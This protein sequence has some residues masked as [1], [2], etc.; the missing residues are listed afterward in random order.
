MFRTR[1]SKK[2]LLLDCRFL[3]LLFGLFLGFL[4]FL[5]FFFRRLLLGFLFGYRS[6]RNPAYQVERPCPYGRQLVKYDVLYRALEVVLLPAHR[7][8]DKVLLG[9]LK[10][11]ANKPGCLLAGYPVPAY[12][13]YPPVPLHEVSQKHDVTDV[14]S[15]AL[16]LHGVL[17]LVYYGRAAG[18]YPEDIAH[19]EYVVGEAPR[20]V[21]ALYLEHL[22]EVRA[23][24]V[25]NP[26]ILLLRDHNL[27][28]ALYALY[29]RLEKLVL[30]LVEGADVQVL[31]LEREM[32]SFI[33]GFSASHLYALV[34]LLD[35]DCH[36]RGARL[37]PRVKNLYHPREA[38]GYLY[39]CCACEVIS[40][41]C[42]LRRGFGQRLRGH[43]THGLFRV[44]V[45][46]HVHGFDYGKQLLLLLGGEPVLL[47]VCL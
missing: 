45:G 2:D 17:R 14:P 40:S 7:R 5:L 28:D 11:C 3:R 26:L 35:M 9:L 38:E 10:G 4:F 6:F 43:H 46:F 41:H 27:R 12:G 32:P 31:G 47:R 21:H 18:L 1:I 24:R 44:V 13:L 8:G 37:L 39:A 36:G 20:V 34:A 42:H 22:L 19:L 25:Y 23:E 16:L 30:H 29:V 15:Q 33:G